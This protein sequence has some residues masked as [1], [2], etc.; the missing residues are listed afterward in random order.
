MVSILLGQ[1]DGVV[2]TVYHPQMTHAL[3]AKEAKRK[4]A[5]GKEKK[6]VTINN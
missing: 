5:L 2:L 6:L 3:A 4:E 1:T